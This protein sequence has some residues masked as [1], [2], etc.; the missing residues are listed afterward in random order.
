MIVDNLFCEVI[1]TTI[2][3]VGYGN[4]GKACERIA[5]DR[6]DMKVA[7]IFTRRNPKELSSP[8]GTPFFAQDELEEFKGKLDVLALCT[9]SA[10][11]LIELGERAAAAFNTVDSFDT[12]AK[13]RGYVSNMTEITLANGTL[14]FIGIGWDPGIFSLM[15]ALFDGVLSNGNTVT[16]WGK[17]V[18]QGHSEAIRKIDGVKRGIQYT[19]P[20]EDA[21][22]AARKG[23]GALLTTRDKHLRECFIVA[24]DDAD[25]V[26]IEAQIKN[27]PNYFSDYDTIVHFISEEEF[28]REHGSMPHGGMVLKSDT[29]NDKTSGLEFKLTLESNPDFTASVLMAYARACKKLYDNGERG[30]KTILDVPV[31][32]LSDKDYLD[33]IASVL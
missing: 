27:M 11:D 29:V 4:L 19:I 14:A 6:Q 23:Q 22:E 20:K 24:S 10:N 5:C 28:D 9:G 31:S 13:M 25:K 26:A 15:R 18:S 33:L 7:A 12:H 17:G 21:L 3:I 1:M 8:F 30:V 16:F 2:G 32:A